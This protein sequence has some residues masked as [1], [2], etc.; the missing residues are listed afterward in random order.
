M[1]K[2]HMKAR[3]KASSFATALRKLSAQKTDHADDDY[4]GKILRPEKS[5]IDSLILLQS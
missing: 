4:Q 1:Y 2:I 3:T 5:K